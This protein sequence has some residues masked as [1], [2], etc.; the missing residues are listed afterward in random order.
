MLPKN[1]P[2]M[3]FPIIGKDGLQGVHTTV[4][5]L[6]GTAKL[7]D[8]ARRVHGIKKGGYIPLVERRVRS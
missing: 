2:V 8:D 6:Q 7:N 4:L 3:T 1:A 5:N